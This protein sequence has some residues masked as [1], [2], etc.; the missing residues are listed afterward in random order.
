MKFLRIFL[1]KSNNNN[2]YLVCTSIVTSFFLLNFQSVFSKNIF[3]QF[4]SRI[5]RTCF[6]LQPLWQTIKQN[7]SPIKDCDLRTGFALTNISRTGANEKKVVVI[8]VSSEPQNIRDILIW[9]VY[10]KILFLGVLQSTFVKAGK[11]SSWPLNVYSSAYTTQIW[12]R[13]G[14]EDIH[15]FAPFC[16][17]TLANSTL[18]FENELLPVSFSW[19]INCM[20]TL[21]WKK[22]SNHFAF[23]VQGIR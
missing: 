15:S 23:Q 22:T 21:R 2:L 16:F 1:P 17:I 5:L 6:R 3:P 12:N 4:N 19:S 7:N 13:I 14:Q 11:S 8:F 18:Y 9:H 20:S 10:H